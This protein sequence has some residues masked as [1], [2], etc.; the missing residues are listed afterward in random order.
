MKNNILKFIGFFVLVA[1]LASCDKEAFEEYS[2]VPADAA[3]TATVSVNSIEDSTATVEYSLSTVGRIFIAVV[4][5][6]DETATPDAQDIL[7]LSVA[8]A[9]FAEQIIMNDAAVLTGSVNVPDLVQNTSYKVF[10]LPV[11]AD[12][13]LGTIVTTD[14][15]STSDT[16][17]PTLDLDAGISPAISSSAAQAIDFA[18]TL[19][20]DEPVVL[21]TGFDIQLGYRNAV[22]QVISWVAVHA[23]SIEVSGN[24]VTIK[25]MQEL[26]NGQY[27]F[28]TI[29]QGA[30]TDRSGNEFEGVTSGIF[31]VPAAL[32]GIFW[33][34]AWE[35]KA[36][37]EV[38]PSDA[39][40]VT[41]AGAFQVIKLVYP[42]KLN[43]L[44][45][46]D[47]ESSFIKVRYF[48]AEVSQDYNVD[49]GNIVIDLDTL[50]ITIPRQAN[51]TEYVSISIAKGAVWDVYG[52][53][54]AVV[55][56]GDYEWFVAY[57]EILDT[58][59]VH[60]ISDYGDP[61]DFSVTMFDNAA[62]GATDDV[63]ITGLFD[64]DAPIV[65]VLDTDAGTLSI[66]LG[67]SFGDLLGDGGEVLMYRW[68]GSFDLSSTI[69]GTIDI[70]G[71]IQ[72]DDWGGVISGGSA[73]YNGYDWDY[74]T[75]GST[76]TKTAKNQTIVKN[77]IPALKKHK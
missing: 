46:V 30:I 74:F 48:D 65:G 70:D 45:L 15:F 36:E 7:K 50:E 16:Y 60:C 71:T 47:Y 53:D 3:N 49:A 10:A 27:V 35:D 5:G 66:T 54:V 51:I 34:V 1:F 25:Q 33:R 52:N 58:Y 31:G 39:D 59:N 18:I 67:Q 29:A 17:I 64:S 23:D 72:L 20:F 14:A 12:G 32:A 38:L 62:S 43:V 68:T 11:N 37:L 57:G 41:N 13:V 24:E 56:F 26:I 42:Y 9:V 76:W 4:P 61:S 73:G 55:E 22:T 44:S 2:S 28:L 21:A 69:V 8:D 19:T 63:V 6:T 40:F 75:A 77:P